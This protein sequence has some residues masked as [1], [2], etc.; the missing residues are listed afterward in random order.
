[1][2]TD[3]ISSSTTNKFI[4]SGELKKQTG[5]FSQ[6]S[7]DNK[8]YVFYVA[9][10]HPSDGGLDTV[11]G[12][13]SF[14]T[15]GAA[16]VTL[17]E[18]KSGAEQPGQSAT[19]T[20]TISANGRATIPPF[21]TGGSQTILYLI[22]A[23]SAFVVGTD[24]G[25][26]FGYVEQQTGGPFSTASINGPFFFG[27][28]APT[29]GVSYN[30]GTVTF[31]GLG[32]ATGNDDSAG[33]NGLKKDIISPTAGGMYSFPAASAPQGKGTIGTNSIAYVISSTEFIFMKTGQDPGL[34]VGQK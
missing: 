31:D 9:G 29:T 8:G 26:A 27:A 14:T 25:V 12:Q 33:P 28:D 20:F 6:T 7:L 23:T 18:N 3:D 4:T 30:S 22:D 11:I 2:T 32:S 17:D 5:P 1:M 21:G 16:T 10:I 24:N 13:S 15:G 19:T 34:I